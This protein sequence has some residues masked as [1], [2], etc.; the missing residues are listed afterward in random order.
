MPLELPCS[1]K[2]CAS[3]SLPSYVL[4]TGEQDRERL[5]ILNELHNPSSLELLDIAPGLRVLTIGCGIGLLELEIARKITSKGVVIATDIS[6]EQ[7]RIAEQNRLEASLDHLQLLQVNALEMDKIPGLFD[8]IHCRYVLTHLPLE[9]GFQILELLYHKITPG[10]FLLLEEIA[11]IHSYQSEPDHLGYDLW[12]NIVQKQFYLQKS[13]PS[14]GLKFLHYLQE[15]KYAISHS[16]FQPLLSTEREKSILS[17]GILSVSKKLLE[18]ELLL[19]QEIEEML[20]LLHQ[21]EK[22]SRIIA[23]YNKISQIKVHR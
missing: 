6:A 9:Q 20:H 12:K 5:I 23:R 13:D 8:R 18:S 3:P 22:D 1:N 4:A 7:L 19:P 21:F 17:L 10:G 11:D 14:P 2:I 15:K 16:F